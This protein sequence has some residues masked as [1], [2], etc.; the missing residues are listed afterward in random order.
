MSEPSRRVTDPTVLRAIAHPVRN[1]ILG[2]LSARGHLRAA[3]VADELGIPANQA[4]FHLRQLAKYGLAEPAPEHAR[5]GRDRVWKPVHPDGLELSP[6]DLLE[7]PGGEAA[8]RVWRREALAQTQAAVARAFAENHPDDVRVVIS[9]DSVRLTKE[10]A[11]A[12]YDELRAVQEKWSAR[13][14]AEDRPGR[15]TYQLLQIL[16]PAG[17]RTAR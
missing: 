10:E 2:E 16:Q 1:R 15:R 13:A 17:D 6:A 5:D 8:V 3:D 9:D 11:G 4:S 14:Q 7:Q 12:L